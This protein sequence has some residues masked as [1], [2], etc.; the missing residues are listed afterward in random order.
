MDS[1]SSMSMLTTSIGGSTKYPPRSP[2][3]QLEDFDNDSFN[4]NDHTI[5]D[6]DDNDND[7]NNDSSKVN[8]GGNDDDL[9]KRLVLKKA[10][11][12]QKREQFELRMREEDADR[13]NERSGAN[14][15]MSEDANHADADAELEYMDEEKRMKMKLGG[16]DAIEKITSEWVSFAQWVRKKAKKKGNLFNF[17]GDLADACDKGDYIRAY[18]IMV[19]GASPNVLHEDRPL[20]YHIFEKIVKMDEVLGTLKVGDKLT[21]DQQ[22]LHSVLDVMMKFSCNIDVINQLDGFAAVHIA[23]AIGSTRLVSWLI[24][25]HCKLDIKSKERFTAIMYAVKYGHVY[26][27]AEIIKRGGVRFLHEPDEERRT[28]LHH[29]AMYGQTR[30]AKFLIKL[31]ADKKKIDLYK[32]QPGQLAQ[33]HGYEVTAQLILTFARMPPKTEDQLQYILDEGSRKKA[34]VQD[35]VKDAFSSI[36]NL[37]SSGMSMFGSMYTK[38]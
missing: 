23:A 10:L 38:K 19:M 32:M 35:T 17:S 5:D 25:H 22:K 31:G 16:D 37:F 4:N 27:I 11:K 36:S 34:S 1:M 20:F 24:D 28:P 9:D 29:A 26:T 3:N 14:G 30:V 13:N 8:S 33:E 6:N 7:D 2:N 18:A 12:S 21:A 15:L